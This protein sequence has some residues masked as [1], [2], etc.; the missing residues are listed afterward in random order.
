MFPFLFQHCGEGPLPSLETEIPNQQ[1]QNQS[2]GQILT[3]ILKNNQHLNLSS[4]SL[5][6]ECGAGIE[7][8]ACKFAG[9][10][11][12]AETRALE[13]DFCCYF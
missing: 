5:E 10:L 13:V 2:R 3:E 11:V 7:S 4:I 9:W 12:V 1:Q 8:R 6:A